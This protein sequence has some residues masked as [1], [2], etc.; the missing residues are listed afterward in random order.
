MEMSWSTQILCFPHFTF[1]PYCFCSSA[2]EAIT[3]GQSSGALRVSAA[4][5]PCYG[6]SVPMFSM[7]KATCICLGGISLLGAISQVL[8]IPSA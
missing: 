7:P 6:L 3:P 1:I 5:H 2:F 4:L 8:G